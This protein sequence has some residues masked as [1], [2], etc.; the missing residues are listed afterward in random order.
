MLLRSMTGVWVLLEG[1]A[2]LL[3]QRDALQL[4]QL[5]IYNGSLSPGQT[6]PRQWSP[7]GPIEARPVVWAGAGKRSRSTLPASAQ[8][9]APRQVQPDSW[10]SP[11]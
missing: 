9:L 3:V 8:S 6:H 11:L 1:T 10:W 2:D 5:V 4:R 7:A